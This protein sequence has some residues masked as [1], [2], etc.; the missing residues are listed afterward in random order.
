MDAVGPVS[1]F[2]STRFPF[3]GAVADFPCSGGTTSCFTS[4]LTAASVAVVET[5]RLDELP[6]ESFR[7]AGGGDGFVTVLLRA[8]AL[9][10]FPFPHGEG[11]DDEETSLRC[12]R[13]AEPT[14][15]GYKNR[16]GSSGLAATVSKTV[17]RLRLF[18]H[19]RPRDNM[20][21][22]SDTPTKRRRGGNLEGVV[23]GVVVVERSEWPREEEAGELRSQKS[24]YYC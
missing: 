19:G 4:V 23:A 5:H 12:C 17:D 18:R 21:D 6:N 2:S 24:Y 9:Y 11:P 22:R 3:C 14:Q 1:A 8:A 13:T 20:W 15:R 10:T 16:R 7:P